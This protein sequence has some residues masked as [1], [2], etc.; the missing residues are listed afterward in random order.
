MTNNEFD[1]SSDP[2]A[3]ALPGD[4]V[5]TKNKEK[6]LYTGK[7]RGR[8]K[9][10]IRVDETMADEYLD[11]CKQGK[12]ITIIAAHFE[13]TEEQLI[14]WGTQDKKRYPKLNSVW[15]RGKTAFKAFHED[16]LDQ[17]IRGDFKAAAQNIASH[18]RRLAVYIDKWNLKQKSQVTVDNRYEAMS[19][20]ELDKEV[21]A[22][23]K[24]KVN[25]ELITRIL[26]IS[27]KNDRP[28]DSTESRTTH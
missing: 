26:D 24:R 11:L 8:K 9:G 27:K 25:K 20:E 12:T 2:E 18:E 1:N 15:E 16:L 10:K 28:E 5:S 21:N 6:K 14:K 22:T 3:L 7:P 17:M 13:T 4:V 23:L 19:D